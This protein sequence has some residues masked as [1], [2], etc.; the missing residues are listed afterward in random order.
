MGIRRFE[1]IEAWQLARELTNGVYDSISADSDF[2]RDYGLKDQVQR[3]AASSMNNIAEGFDAEGNTEFLRFL[4]YANRSCTEV[5][6]QLYLAFD[7]KY[8]SGTDFE[9]LYRLAARTR[10]AI[11][12]FMKYLRDNER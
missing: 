12:A 9:K 5:Q 2:A 3:A 11:H 10:S 6:S 7:R 1:D 8:I 4:G